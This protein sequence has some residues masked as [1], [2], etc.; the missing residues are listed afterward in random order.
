MAEPV[1]EAAEAGD[2][3]VYDRWSRPQ[4]LSNRGYLL[5]AVIP[6]LIAAAGF[7]V[8]ALVSS[9]GDSLSG[10]S[11]HLPVSGYA[12]S[13]QDGETTPI[14]G[15]LRVD[16]DHCVYLTPS[17][18]GGNEPDQVWPVWP[19]GYHGIRDGNRVTIYDADDHAVAV[20]GDVVQ[21]SGGYVPVSTFA[22]EPC[23]PEE[24][25]VAVVQSDVTVV[26]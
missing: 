22:T 1:D 4:A 7:G 18:R 16:A 2:Q 9:G 11:V 8:V 14:E 17:Q 23:L 26:Q 21:M 19:A 25:Q 20:D 12:P 6:F 10:T 5:V 24:G 15:T 3:P 13:G